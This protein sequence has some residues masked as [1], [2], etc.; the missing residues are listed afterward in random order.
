MK[1]VIA[2][3][4]LLFFITTAFAQKAA[5]VVG[6]DENRL[7]RMDA[8]IA[9]AVERKELPGAVVIVGHRGKIVWRKAYG[10][11]ALLPQREAMTP[12]TIFDAAS[13]TKVVATA[14]SIMLLVER[15]QVRLN[16]PVSR[17]IPELKGEGRDALTVEHLLTHLGGYAPDFDL[18]EKWTGYDEAIKR[19]AREPLRNAPDTRFVYSDIGF[20]ALGEIVRRVSGESLGEFARHNIFD[21]LDMKDTGFNPAAALKPRIAPT[22][23]KRGQAA[24]LGG[25]GQAANGDDWLRGEVHDPTSYRMGGV[26]GHAGLFTAADDLAR[27]CR[28]MLNGGQLD[29]VRLLS[30]ATVAEM[31]HPRAVNAEGAARGLGWDMHTSF[32]NNR[33]DLFPRGTYGHTGFTGTSLW[34]DPASDTFVVFLMHCRNFRP[35]K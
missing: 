21:P 15:G 14:T 17:Y 32:S 22:E 30:P 8:L 6:V 33:G 23:Q 18:R 1:H 31:T 27:Y 16:D 9:Q 20:I 28:M 4:I 13:L 19:L 35:M 26:A 24:Y 3:I 5:P 11:R 34:L 10:S 29:G 25:D 7:A 2:S 12:D